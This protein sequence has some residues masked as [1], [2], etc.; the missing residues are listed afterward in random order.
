MKYTMDPIKGIPVLRF[1]DRLDGYAA[2]F[3]AGAQ[4]MLA[5]AKDLRV[6]EA[7]EA[8]ARPMPEQAKSQEE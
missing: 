7:Q 3:A 6:R 4:A 1:C 2:G 8:D 5:V